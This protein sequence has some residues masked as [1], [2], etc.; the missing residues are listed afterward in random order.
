MKLINFLTLIIF[1]IIN[2]GCTEAQQS[3]SISNTVKKERINHSERITIGEKFKIYSKVLGEE[4]EI[5]VSLPHKYEERVHDYPVVFVLE[6]EFLFEAA[7][8]VTKYMAARSKMPQSIIVGLA[9]GTHEKRY[10]LNLKKWNG[11]L[12]EYLS[13]FNTELIPYIEKKYRANSHRTI[14]G[15]SPTNGFLFEAFLSKPNMFKGYIALSAHLEWNRTE[16]IKLFDE[17]ISIANNSNYP[18]N[19]LYLGRADSDLILHSSAKDAY[20]DAKQKLIDQKPIN[21][22][23]NIDVLDNE[24]HYLMSLAGIR[25]GFA[26]IYPDS[27]WRNPGWIG[28]D[29]DENYAINHYKTYY[30]KLS[31]IYGFDIYPVED[32]HSYGYYLVGK[33]YSAKKWGTNKQLIDLL[34][35]GIGYYPNSANLHIMLAEA[36]YTKG[37]TKLASEIAK[38]AI[39]L[40]EKYHPEELEGYKKRLAQ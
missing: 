7:S 33:A 10:D 19:A 28:W 27:L 26:T 34:E 30:D 14:I 9:N 6:A 1:I 18:K 36:Y 38:K 21:A 3:K 5:Y 2:S 20:V 17:I 4:K 37:D 15:L 16:D 32:G 25:N 22:T 23:I 24:E 8:T 29:K 40:A 35:L 11:K 31:S 39:K 12:D 13:F